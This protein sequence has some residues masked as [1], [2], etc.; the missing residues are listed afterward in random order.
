MPSEVAPLHSLLEGL[1]NTGDEPDRGEILDRFLAYTGK[2]GFELYPAQE[3]A[4]L[5]LLEWRHVI[6]NTPTGSGKSLVA[7]FLHFQA[8]AEGRRSYYTSP[9]KALVNEKFFDL[10]EAF[11][12]ENVG[13]LTGDASVNR[14]APVVCCTAEI[15][16]NMALRDPELGADYVVM[17][18]FHFYGDKE[19]GAAWQIPLITLRETVFLLMSA[20]LGDMTSIAKRIEEYTDR[21]VAVIMGADRPVPLT[22]EYRETA[23]QETIE[24]LLGESEAPIYLVNFTQRSCAENAQAL[25]SI[26]VNTREERQAIG[27]ELARMRFDTPYGKELQR[28]LRAGIGVH[29]AGLLPKYR[30]MVE[31]LAQ[32]GMLKVVSGT[33]SLGVGVNIPIRTVLFT[34]LSKFNGERTAILTAREFHQLAG[35]AGRRGF[36]DH[37]RV[38][39][40]APEHVAEN[41]KLEAKRIKS[42]HLKN[43]LVNKKPP[44]GFVHYDDKTFA[45]LVA[46]QP[47]ALEPRFEV[48]HGMII[49]VLQGDADQGPGYGRLVQTIR[50][51]H[52]REPEQRRQLRLAARLFRS[53]RDARIV[54]LVRGGEGRGSVV[55]VSADLQRDFSLHQALS[56]YLVEVIDFLDR[57]ADSWA[58]EVL[59]LVESILEDP[60]PV[61]QRQVDRIKDELVGRLKA[62]GV[63]YEERMAQLEKVEHPKP[64]AE[65]I[66]DT[67][68]IF[69]KSHPWVAAENIRPKSVARDM[70][71]KCM[72]FNDYVKDLGIAR[73]EGVLLRYLSQVYK[74]CLQNVPE[75]YH[76]EAFSDVVAFL[77]TVLM[78]VD[79]SLIDEWERMMRGEIVRPKDRLR[80]L[81]EPARPT[82]LASD[83]KAFSRRIRNEL[84]LLLKCLASRTWDD[85]AEYVRFAA[86]DPWPAERFE[87]VLEPYFAEHA[88]IDVSPRAR[89]VQNTILREDGPRRWTVLHKIVDP[90]GDEDWVVEGVVD[91]EQIV[92]ESLPLVELRRIGT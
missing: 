27:A 14:D 69:A 66:Y 48:S 11:G 92:D 1:R 56:L 73:S 18:E 77:R 61:L 30:L 23:L 28:F 31:K 35:R 47:E 24:A 25:T 40:L 36:D 33:D 68:N 81:E 52:L 15:L 49:Q 5:E 2:L 45:R 58:L 20:T 32:A 78:H 86:D 90:E 59:T 46:A 29:H 91:L 89:H 4:I 21:K 13:L 7:Q 76:D 67:F 84:F 75:A 3:Q 12:A 17:D 8:A 16:A 39:G 82:D 60:T 85:A 53:L 88:S 71:E 51:T 44:R 34:S 22:F 83:F 9:I 57:A 38:V 37:G 72:G 63:E 64:N 79:S 87:A 43:K 41:K 65:F 10:C 26:Q 6:L 42:P 55:R 54:E 70:Y 80:V 62:E 74:T 50:R 19:R